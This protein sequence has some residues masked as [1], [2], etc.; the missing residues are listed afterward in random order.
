MAV[1]PRAM[2]YRSRLRIYTSSKTTLPHITTGPSWY[3]YP[4]QRK[5]CSGL[6]SILG[7]GRD[8]FTR[9]HVFKAFSS[10]HRLGLQSPCAMQPGCCCLVQERCTARHLCGV[11][12]HLHLSRTEN[13]PMHVHPS[14][15]HHRVQL[16]LDFRTGGSTLVSQ[17]AAD[18]LL[19]LYGS[20]GPASYC[21]LLNLEIFEARR[22]DTLKA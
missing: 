17:F 6:H 14:G 10:S 2:H 4:G 20:R 8:V 21:S 22:V 3:I 9:H 1:S 15:L 5:F 19:V 12:H 7:L 18:I 11:L 16:G 13:S